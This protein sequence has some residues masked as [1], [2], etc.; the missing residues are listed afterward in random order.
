MAITLLKPKQVT[1]AVAAAGDATTQAGAGEPAVTPPGKP[2]SWLM[3]GSPADEAL[4]WLNAQDPDCSRTEWLGILLLAAKKGLPEAPV[5]AWSMKS[6][7]YQKATFDAAWKG[8]L[9]LL[10]KPYEPSGTQ[11]APPTHEQLAAAVSLEQ[12]FDTWPDATADHPYLTKKGV[13]PTGLKIIPDGCLA[14]PICTLEGKFCSVQYIDDGGQKKNAPGCAFGSGMFVAGNVGLDR[15][16]FVCEGL[17]TAWACVQA[18]GGAAA[19]TFGVGRT[20]TV[21]KALRDHY[22]SNL[23]I[24]LVPDKGQE[25]QASA[26]AQEV[27]GLMV[28]M[29][30]DKPS[31][32]DAWDFLSD[33]GSIALAGML[34]NA[35]A[36]TPHP[37]STEPYDRLDWT[38]AGNAALIAHLLD[39]NLRY[40][41]ERKRWISWDGQ[42][43][44]ADEDGSVVQTHALKVAEH[45]FGR[46]TQLRQSV[47]S[48]PPDVRARTEKVAVTT[49][50]WAECCRSK[51]AL[52]AMID[53]ASRIPSVSISAK[54]LDACPRLLGAQNGVIDLIT[55]EL[56]EAARDDFVTRRSPLSFDA[57]AACPKWKQFIEQIT[58]APIPPQLNGAGDVIVST[59]GQFKPRPVLADYLQR[60]AGYIATGGVEQHKLFV[61]VGSGSNGKSVLLDTLRWVLG[62]YATTCP[63]DLLL[64]TKAGFSGAASP[65]IAALAGARLALAS[66]SKENQKFAPAVIKRLTGGDTLTGR[67]LYANPITFEPSHKVVLMTNAI[68][69]LDHLDAAIKGRLHLIPFDRRW[70]RPGESDGDPAL[71]D[72]GEHLVDDLRA[73]GPGILAW[74]VRGAVA[75]QENKLKPP[76]EVVAMT[77]A[78]FAEQD[79]LGKWLNQYELCSPK[80]GTAAKLLF[81]A[82]RSWCDSEGFNVAF[83]KN[84]FSAALLT[85][86]IKKESNNKGTWYGLTL[87]NDDLAALAAQL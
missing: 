56:R 74:I 31:N 46:A 70:N 22:G 36:S 66:E 3:K 8:G 44:G 64:E 61:A 45:Y 53:L 30:D 79:V 14:V 15:P 29:P 40:V 52:T 67:F 82:F 41:H 81:E 10:D 38:D 20:G 19:V 16:M 84:S 21:T 59:V 71:P 39:G 35:K 65:D 18:T 42:R 75:Y 17:A 50:K 63:P 12:Q 83:S 85:R 11:P 6:A 77:K 73:E 9:K 26:F 54:A 58:A 87:K 27:G 1:G 32:Y 43:W 55:G 80:E 4:S 78:Y 72:G 76:T 25:A 48:A 28:T 49:E 60:L 37:G 62:D 47:K 86:Q 24:V 2:A 51:K 69:T 57:G 33:Q 7:K 5:R 68:P 23:E 34:T 13:P